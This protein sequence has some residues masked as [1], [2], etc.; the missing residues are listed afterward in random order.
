[1]VEDL[2]AKPEQAI[3]LTGTP[4]ERRP[5]SEVPRPPAGSA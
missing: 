5:G 1:M 3:M 2:V 4:Q